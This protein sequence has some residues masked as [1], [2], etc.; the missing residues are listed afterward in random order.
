MPSGCPLAPWN[1]WRPAP[2]G[3]GWRRATCCIPSLIVD[4]GC[5]GL[6]GNDRH[7]WQGGSALTCV[8]ITPAACPAAAPT[9]MAVYAAEAVRWAS[10][11][12]LC[13]VRHCKEAT[14]SLAATFHSRDASA[15]GARP[16][17]LTSWRPPDALGRR[18]MRCMGWHRSRRRPC[19]VHHCCHTVCPCERAQRASSTIRAL[20]AASLHTRAL[21]CTGKAPAYLLAQSVAAALL[22]KQAEQALVPPAPPT[23]P[24]VLPPLQAC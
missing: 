3:T 19:V 4:R 13:M 8:D 7:R 1:R 2:L 21:R 22:G 5:T 23:S 11:R 18:P 14:V 16:A 17:L 10:C 6:V 24:S 9:V 12:A 20:R 15:S